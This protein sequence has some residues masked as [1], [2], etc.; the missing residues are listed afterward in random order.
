MNLSRKTV[1]NGNN[2]FLV[3]SKEP[4][5]ISEFV[6]KVCSIFDNY[7]YKMCVDLED[8]LELYHRGDIF[9]SDPMIIFLWELT[10]ESIKEISPTIS[11][12]T[13]DILI[14]AERKILAKNK[15][16]TNFRAECSM[17]KLD[18]IDEKSC[19]KWVSSRMTSMS[20][21]YE[22]DVPKLLVE[23]KSNN[24]YALDSEIR[25]L[26]VLY[27]DK[28]IDK[29]ALIYVAE[30]SDARVFEF[31]EHLFH[32]RRDK[33]L[34]EFYK[35]PEESYIKLV[36]MLT[37]NIEKV[38]K[39]AVYRSQKKSAEEISD[40]IGINKFIIKTKYFTILSVYGKIKLLKLIDLFNNLDYDLRISKMPKKLLFEAYLLKSLTI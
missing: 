7:A 27:G 1:E 40:L 19:L 6:E 24:L 33:A 5:L 20:L 3:S 30:S 14:F 28:E 16:Y 29:S 34:Q 25:K 13:D 8:F 31:I 9:S 36:R 39:I 18:P 21:R 10:A 32:K 11:H 15:A 38:Y 12:H 26:R 37:S 23:K 35:F 2:K 4:Y 22:R 17:I